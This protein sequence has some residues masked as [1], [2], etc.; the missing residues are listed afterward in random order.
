V[1]PMLEFQW[2]PAKAPSNLQKHGVPF[3]YAARVFLDERR[4]EGVDTRHRY[5]EE[6]LITVGSIEERVYVV[7]YTRRR[8][9]IRLISARKANARETQKY[10]AFSA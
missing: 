6:R 1:L 4:Q 8:A 3:E 7:A 10:Q 2:D 5:G 9:A